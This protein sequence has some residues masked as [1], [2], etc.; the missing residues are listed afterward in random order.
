MKT[1]WFCKI[2]KKTADYLCKEIKSEYTLLCEP[3]QKSIRA[4]VRKQKEF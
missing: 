4:T 3:I 1:D 2:K